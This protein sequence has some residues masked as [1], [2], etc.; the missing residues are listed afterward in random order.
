MNRKRCRIED[1]E[2]EKVQILVTKHKQS[3]IS[4]YIVRKRNNS[5]TKPTDYY[6]YR[7]HKIM[8]KLAILEKENK[9]LFSFKK[10]FNFHDVYC[11]DI[12]KLE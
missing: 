7:F 2:N 9:R 5:Q 8:D 1:N 11:I 12:E 3:T 10:L 4:L 6:W